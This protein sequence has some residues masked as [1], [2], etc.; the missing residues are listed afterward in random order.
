M[1]NCGQEYNSQLKGIQARLSQAENN[2]TNHFVGV[3]TAVMGLLA[4]PLTAGSVAALSGIYNLVP[5]GLQALQNLISEIGALDPKKIMMEAAVAL[6]DNMEA[7]LGALA[8]MAMNA[9]QAIIDNAIAAVENAITTATDLI[10]ALPAAVANEAIALTDALASGVLSEIEAATNT[11]HAAMAGIGGIPVALANAL[12]TVHA[13]TIAS[14]AAKNL[15]VS[16]NT[17]FKAQQN[18][19]K[20]KSGSMHIG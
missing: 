18:V 17:F 20:C 1:S 16:T 8:D 2:I 14:D 7:E 13:T 12:S 6:M 4:N 9:A 10:A 19:S 15:G 5:A 11:L 3:S